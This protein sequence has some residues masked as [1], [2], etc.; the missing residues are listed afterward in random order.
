MYKLQKS[1]IKK[2][3]PRFSE[4]DFSRYVASHEYI[5]EQEMKFKQ[6][7]G[8]VN[9]YAQAKTNKLTVLHFLNILSIVDKNYT[10]KLSKV[11]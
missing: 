6:S 1:S 5:I 11:S 7:A 4:E 2:G 10:N 8:Y 9:S 3:C